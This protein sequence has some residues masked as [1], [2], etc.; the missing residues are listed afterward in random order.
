MEQGRTVI[1]HTMK[2]TMQIGNTAE[3]VF[4]V[5][6]AMQP[7]FNGNIVHAVCSTWDLAH[8]FE[9]AA[10]AA[11]VPHLEDHEEGIGSHLS[12][13][14]CAPAPLNREVVVRATVTKIDE[15]TVVCAME[16][17]CG[18]STIATGEQIQ[19]IFPI[20]IVKQIIANASE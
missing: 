19:R 15:T 14:H 4:I 2:S 17:K 13:D 6:D 5:T 7:R 16:G 8:Q 1:A 10:R 12:I 11:L 9:L 20:E 3:V 18:E